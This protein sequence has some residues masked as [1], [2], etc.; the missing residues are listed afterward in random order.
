MSDRPNVLLITTDQQRFDTI[1]AAGNQHIFTPHL[2]WL[3]H[4]GIHFTRCYTDAPI[5]VA[6]RA[7]IMTGLHG[8]TTGLIGNTGAI[9][10]MAANP[11]LPGILT[12]AGYQTRA[13]GKMHFEP[14]RA[15]YGFEYMEILEDYYRYMAKHPHLGVPMDHGMGQNEMEPVISTVSESSS[16]T[17]WTVE[18]SIDFLETRDE[19]RPFFLWTSF[20]KPHPPFD[21]VREYWELYQNVALPDPVVGDW[22]ARIE[23][24]PD[25][26][27]E[28]TRCLNHVDRFGPDQM[29]ASKRAYYACISQID[30]NLGLLFARLRE[31]K[32]FENTWILFTADHGEMLGDHHMGGKSHFLEGAAHVPM[33]IRPPGPCWHEE[34]LRGTRCDRLVCLADVLPTVLAAA[35]VRP[36]EGFRCDGL[37]MLAVARGEAGRDTFYGM[38]PGGYHAVIQGRFKYQF[39]EHGA[40]ELLFDLETDPQERHELVR[41]GEVPDVLDRLRALMVAHLQ[42][43][44][45]DAVR[46]GRLVSTGPAPNAEQMNSRQWPGF[47]SRVVPADVLH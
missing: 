8:Y 17:H 34:P 32:L 15:N 29:R 21:C 47:H 11:T 28:S 2:N 22:S 25:A 36:P 37:D 30:Y 41:S 14:R 31:L 39:A 5:C 38:G 42:R 4:E 13:Q 7:T 9:K 26:F 44:R 18:R 27:L 19:T 40:N 23:D 43:Y 45:P 10:P 46:D 3:L 24:I 1:A 35:G 16:L 12:A 33:L 6:A 20:A